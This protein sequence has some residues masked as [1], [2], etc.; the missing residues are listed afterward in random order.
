MATTRERRRYKRFDMRDHICKLILLEEPDGSPTQADCSL[1]D[2]SYGGMRFQADR[3]LTLGQMYGFVIELETPLKNSSSVEA[4]ICWVQPAGSRRHHLGALFLKS[5][6][7]W[8]GPA[9]VEEV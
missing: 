6:K 2:L 3:P 7:A 1:L 8:L 5:S 9:E 4:R